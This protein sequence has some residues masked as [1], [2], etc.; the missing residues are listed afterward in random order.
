MV[1]YPGARLPAGAQHRVTATAAAVELRDLFF[2]F[3]GIEHMGVDALQRVGVDPALDVAHVLQGV[4]QVEHAA[5]AEH[6]VEVQVFGQSFPQF[7]GMFVDGGGLVPQVVGAH[8]SGVACRIAAAQ[9]A[10]FQ[11]RDAAHLRVVFGQV[12]GG[13]QAMPAAADDHHVVRGFQRHPLPGGFP[14]SVVFKSVLEQAPERV[15]LA[16]H[17]FS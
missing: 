15:I 12:V 4:A 16:A 2:H 10:F 1:R 5:L 14:A 17:G 9:I 13:G 7:Q 8:D 3:L 11:H 6:D